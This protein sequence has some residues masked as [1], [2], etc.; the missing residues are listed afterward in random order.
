MKTKFYARATIKKINFPVTRRLKTSVWVCVC[1]Y[2]F[3]I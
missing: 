2:V 1:M 3:D